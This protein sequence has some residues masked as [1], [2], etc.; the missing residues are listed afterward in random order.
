MHPVYQVFFA[1]L[2]PSLET[3]RITFDSHLARIANSPSVVSLDGDVY[4]K[5]RF[6]GDS[7]IMFAYALRG[8]LVPD[9]SYLVRFLD[10]SLVLCAWVKPYDAVHS[11]TVPTLRFPYLDG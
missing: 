11:M 8:V 10:T 4:Y 5:W 7:R 1:D 3:D 6:F 9:T 2:D